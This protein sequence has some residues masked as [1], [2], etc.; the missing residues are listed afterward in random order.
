MTVRWPNSYQLLIAFILFD[1]E[2]VVNADLTHPWCNRRSINILFFMKR[3]ETWQTVVDI[4]LHRSPREVGY[5]T[6]QEMRNTSS[7]SRGKDR[8]TVGIQWR[9]NSKRAIRHTLRRIRR[10][11]RPTAYITDHYYTLKPCA[12]AATVNTALTGVVNGTQ[13]L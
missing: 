13:C 5:Y 2:R 8:F 10:C 9:S 4:L 1:E 6:A 12:G 3:W 11:M 7:L